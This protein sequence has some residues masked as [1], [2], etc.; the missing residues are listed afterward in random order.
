[1]GPRNVT[2]HYS[3][4]YHEDYLI[5]SHL[6][7]NHVYRESASFQNIGKLTLLPGHNGDVTIGSRK[8][9]SEP[10]YIEL[11]NEFLGDKTTSYGGFL[12]FTLLTHDLQAKFN[13]NVLA[14]YPLVQMHTHYHLVLNHFHSEANEQVSVFNIV[15]HESQWKHASNGYNISRA[16]M[17]TALQNIKRILVRVTTSNGF[18]MTS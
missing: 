13:K 9:F 6:K 5:L 3:Q 7:N 2:V 18:I 10:L 11:P 16:I 14:K 1:M 15:L 17:M 12:N 4:E 8:L